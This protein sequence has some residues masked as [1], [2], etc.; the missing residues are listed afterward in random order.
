[1]TNKGRNGSLCNACS[2][3]PSFWLLLFLIQS[4]HAAQRGIPFW[5]WFLCFWLVFVLLA[6]SVFLSEWDLEWSC[7]RPTSEFSPPLSSSFPFSGT[8]PPKF[9]MH[10]L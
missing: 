1:M 10:L 9:P 4:K 7:S 8:S 6:A 2:D 3:R 5:D